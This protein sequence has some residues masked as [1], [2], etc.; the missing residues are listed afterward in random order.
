MQ[1]CANGIPGSH[2]PKSYHRKRIEESIT[3]KN[4]ATTNHKRP[5]NNNNSKRITINVSGSIFET[6]EETLQRFPY[7][8]LGDKAKRN[9]YYCS[10]TDQYYFDRNRNTFECVLFFYQSNGNLYRPYNVNLILFLEECHFFQLPRESIDVVKSVECC[11]LTDKVN[12]ARCFPKFNGTSKIQ[13]AVWNFL[14]YPESSNQARVYFVTQMIFIVFSIALFSSESLSGSQPTNDQQQKH[15]QYKAKQQQLLNSP[16]LMIELSITVIFGLDF[17]LRCIFSPH[18]RQHFSSFYMYLDLICLVPYSLITSTD[19]TQLTTIARILKM[20]R[21]L[22]IL[23][24]IRLLTRISKKLRV[25]FVIINDSWRDLQIFALGILL[26]I[27]VSATTVFVCEVNDKDTEFTS[28]PKAMWW[29]LQ[30]CISLGYG[31]IV[32]QTSLG[33]LVSSIYM[34]YGLIWMMLPIISLG[35]KVVMFGA[36]IRGNRN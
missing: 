22:R 24:L 4:S 17:L 21:F 7:S 23:K 11:F 8:L 18:K 1:S 20:L 30:A 16:F 14:E 6:F 9:Q 29:S 2:L 26:I 28:I 35:L 32:P 3:Q 27:F 10:E 19:D 33:R 15:D 31:D 13:S 34:V 25:L 12:S 36:E 5:N